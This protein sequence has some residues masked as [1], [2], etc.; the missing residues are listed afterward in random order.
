MV[1]P[2]LRAV[3]ADEGIDVIGMQ[4]G[5]DYLLDEIATSDGPAEVLVLGCGSQIP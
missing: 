3:F 2:G 4:S 1:T 5:A